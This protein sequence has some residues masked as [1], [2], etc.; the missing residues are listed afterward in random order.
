MTLSATAL[1]NLTQ[2]KNY[3]R[4]DAAASLH[5]DAEFVGVGDGADK[6]FDLDH[7]PVG[8]SL[9]LYVD[10][11][12]QVETTDYS[13]SGVTVTFVVAPP[14]NDG[15]TANYDYDASADTFEAYDDDLLERLVAA[16][17]KKAEDYTG[18]VFIQREL[19]ETHIGDGQQVLR[20]YK[21]PVDSV[22]GITIGGDALT[23]YT[24]RLTVGRIY[25]TVVWPRDYEVVV[26]YTAGY[27][28]NRATTQPLVPDAVTAVLLILAN[29]YE[30]RVD[31]VKSEAVVGVG[32][33]TYDVP[34][35]AKEL[36]NPLRVNVL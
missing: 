27:G 36:L 29:L 3:L 30:N 7:T 4:V 6:T 23:T 25:H 11:T 18:R 14:L 31:Q 19:V 5:V 17:T 20:L 16:A 34:S 33:V 21:R 32:S 24:E 1:V 26:T 22:A 12:L 2:A 10:N 28:T 35:Q 8:G 9:R 15:I 13:I